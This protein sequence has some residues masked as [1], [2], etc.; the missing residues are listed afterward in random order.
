MT[1]ARAWVARAA[2]IQSDER[3]GCCRQAT[4]GPSDR[5]ASSLPLITELHLSSLAGGARS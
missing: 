3:C 5:I 1:T 4:Y 2:A